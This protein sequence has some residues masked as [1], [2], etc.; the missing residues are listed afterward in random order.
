MSLGKFDGV[1]ASNLGKLANVAS[2]NIGKVV[3]NGAAV[4][5][6]DGGIVTD[7]AG[8]RYHTFNSSGTFTVFG[9]GQV[10]VEIVAGGGGGATGIGDPSSGGGGGGAGGYQE[11]TGISVTP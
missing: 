6:A 2:S 3:G 8:Y 9:S 5:F 11:K 4:S 7:Y 1:D 10:D